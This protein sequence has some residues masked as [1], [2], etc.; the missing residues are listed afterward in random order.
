MG[1]FKA[2][3]AEIK[4]RHDR[5][6]ADAYRSALDRNAGNRSA[7]ARELGVH[8][9][10]VEKA[11]DRYGIHSPAVRGAPRRDLDARDERHGP[12][13]GAPRKGRT[14]SSDASLLQERRRRR[15]RR[16]S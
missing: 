6:L 9:R 10:A 15:A 8:P 16:D 2:T 4:E 12:G 13:R 7:A 5:E 3:I 14:S 11:I 1:E